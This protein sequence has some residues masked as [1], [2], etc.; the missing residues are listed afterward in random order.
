MSATYGSDPGF[1]VLI[2][3]QRLSRA[4]RGYAL[5]AGTTIGTLSYAGDDGSKPT[6]TAFADGRDPVPADIYSRIYQT[7]DRLHA[8]GVS[9]RIEV[10]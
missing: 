4:D 7:I 8:A 3:Q 1:T 9:F 10:T 5:P 2:E 6:V